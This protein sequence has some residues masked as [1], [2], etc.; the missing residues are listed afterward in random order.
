M[1]LAA[2]QAAWPRVDAFR[3]QVEGGFFNHPSDPGGPTHAGVALRYVVHLDR[4]KDGRLDFDLDADGDVDIEDIKALRHRPDKVEEHYLNTYW[5]PSKASELAWPLCLYV[6]DAAVHHG[7]ET[8]VLLLQRGLGD[9]KQDGVPGPKTLAAARAASDHAVRRVLAE[10]GLL[11]G[12]IV[13]AQA[14]RGL[15]A[16][17]RPDARFL[18]ADVASDLVKRIGAHPFARGWY[19]RLFDLQAEGLRPW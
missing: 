4:D 12:R 11:M 6:F 9:L 2:P 1:G 8:S 13:G 18:P 3:R 7:V 10:R 16:Q 19:Q 15:L 5:Y 14:K 17:F